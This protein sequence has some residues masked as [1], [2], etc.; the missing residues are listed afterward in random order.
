[1]SHPVV[2]PHY[3]VILHHICKHI[4]GTD[5][6]HQYFL[7]LFMCDWFC[8]SIVPCTKVHVL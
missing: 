6:L 8:A 2:G 5:A 1:M 7:V 4:L 3:I